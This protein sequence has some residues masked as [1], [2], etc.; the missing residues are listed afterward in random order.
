MYHA[1]LQQIY[2]DVNLD[3][4]IRSLAV[5]SLKNGIDKY[6]RKSAKGAIQP[7]EKQL[8]KQNQLQFLG[9]TNRQL[10]T[11]HAVIIAKIARHDFPNEWP[12]LLDILMPVV[13]QSFNSNSSMRFNSLY[14]L[15]L[16]M[17]SLTSK[18]LPSAKRITQM[19]TPNVF[20]FTLTV[21]HTQLAKFFAL[22]EQNSTDVNEINDALVLS[23]VALKCLR[24]LTINGYQKFSEATEVTEL[25]ASLNGY[26]PKLQTIYAQLSSTA[27]AKPISNTL[28]GILMLFGK[29]FLNA[30]TDR[31]VDFML[32]PSTIETVRIYWAF[33][34]SETLG[35]DPLYE[36][37]KIQALK[38]LKNIV[39]HP[40][41]HVVSEKHADPRIPEVL[42]ILH[43][44]LTQEFILACAKTLLSRY[45]CLSKSDLE[46]W[47]DDPESFNQE[48]ES[49]HWEF[50]I[51]G[52]AEKLYMV[53]NSKYREL[54]SPFLVNTLNSLGDP[55]AS[56]LLFLEGLYCVFGSCAFELYDYFDF[57]QWFETK[58]IF[59]VQN[60]LP[61]FKVLRR[62][63]ADLMGHWVGVKSAKEKRAVLYEAIISLLQPGE[64]TVVRLRATSNL[65]KLIDD[66]DFDPAQFLPYLQP[67]IENFKDL[68]DAV[69]EF[70]SKITIIN[71]LIAITERLE[72]QAVVAMAPLFSVIHNLWLRSEG[73]NM[74]R[75][76]IVKILTKFVKT[77]RGESYQMYEMVAPILQESL[78]TSNPGHVYLFEEGLELWLATM[79]N[80]PR[81]HQ[82]LLNLVPIAISLLDLG[83]ETLK[84]IIH[85]LEAYIVVCP[86]EIFQ[87]YI[88]PITTTVSGMLENVSAPAVG[89]LLKMI[90]LIIQS[91]NNTNCIPALF[92]VIY[93]SGFFNK[94][95]SVIL[96]GEDLSVVIIAYM[97]VLAR[98][99]LYDP[100]SV[101]HAFEAGGQ[102]IIDRLLLAMI[103]KFDALS[104]IRQ[105]KLFALSFASLISTGHPKVVSKLGE[106]FAIFTS[107]AVQLKDLDRTE[108]QLFS[109]E[110]RNEDDDEFSLDFER[111]KYL[112]SLDPLYMEGSLVPFIKTKLAEFEQKVGTAY[113]NELTRTIDQDI[114]LQINRMF[115]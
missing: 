55:N 46:L 17:K 103:D 36:N 68:L 20:R 28:N 69:D 8:I 65:L 100:N 59:Q 50:N 60:K 67:V 31:V 14:T 45:I 29:L 98:M 105:S 11:Q 35:D 75:T 34:E 113:L 3:I 9:E 39:K 13:E 62:R 102:D 96:I 90:D 97:M 53:L 88:T 111:R 57:D 91:A 24:R 49:D 109:F 22:V 38:I 56:N 71:C 19:I 82:G 66:F 47:E 77:L 23:K 33:V 32:V 42:N 58:L 106:F 110:V 108:A 83:T 92:N 21:F 51:R 72:G 114:M 89:T 4:K 44:I 41:Y 112:N 94:L 26:L 6:W 86:Q 1:T 80:C 99:V 7:Q 40:A 74:F 10:A 27:S 85:I 12:D 30:S 70:D 76:S 61:E 79:Q 107:V 78:D 115:Q 15:H 25:F 64:D 101:L 5:I 81:A 2:L 52:C 54:L 16:V 87:S 95:V 104:H 63:I 37:I 43:G 93:S 18:A 84:K 48:E 73:Q